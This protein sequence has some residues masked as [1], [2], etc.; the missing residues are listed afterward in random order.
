MHKFLNKYN[1]IKNIYEILNFIKTHADE[2][3]FFFLE[4]TEKHKL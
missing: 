3:Q 4:I 2:S 1:F